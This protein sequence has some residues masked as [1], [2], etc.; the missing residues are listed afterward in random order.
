MPY[1][2]VVTILFI[3]GLTRSMQLTALNTIAFSDVEPAHRSSASTL[4]T[5]L[6]H[7]AMLLGVALAAACLNIAQAVRG[8][9]ALALGDFSFAFVVVALLALLSAFLMLRLPADAGSEVTGHR[10]TAH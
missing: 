9:A 8:D 1:A 6:Q 2:V 7:V 4:S 3:A 5:M 10:V